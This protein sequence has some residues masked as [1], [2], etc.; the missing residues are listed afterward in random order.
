MKLV[1]HVVCLDIHIIG[2]HFLDA[3]LRAAE[4]RDVPPMAEEQHWALQEQ[5]CPGRT[6]KPSD[7]KH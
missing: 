4:G 6:P 3:Q 1:I 5:P 2:L 7:R